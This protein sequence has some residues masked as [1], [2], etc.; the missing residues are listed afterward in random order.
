MNSEQIQIEIRRLNNKI[1]ISNK[2]ISSYRK[3]IREL[4]E[5]YNK[6]NFVINIFQKSIQSF[7]DSI[8]KSISKLD[9]DSVFGDYYKSKIN[10]ILNGTENYQIQETIAQGKRD[11]LRKIDEKENSIII[12]ERNITK[13]SQRILELKN[14]L[15][16]SV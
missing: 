16:N 3:E 4:E 10:P 6:S 11:I 2:N 9:K 13:Y 14:M 15:L 12:E 8:T 7:Y 5:E 1:N